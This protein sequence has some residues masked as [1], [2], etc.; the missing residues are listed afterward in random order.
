MRFTAESRA[1]AFPPGRGFVRVLSVTVAA[2]A[3]CGC[4]DDGDKASTGGTGGLLVTGTG[5]NDGGL[6]GGKPGATG[7]GG[8]SGGT[9]STGGR[10]SV[11]GTTSSG[12]T[13]SSGGAASSGGTRPSG[14]GGSAAT[15]QPIGAICVNDSNCSQ[16]QGMATC[17]AIPTCTGPCECRLAADCPKTGLFLECKGAADCGA[18]GGGKVCCQIASGSQTMQYCTKPSGCSGK[19]LP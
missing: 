15:G 18:F 2:L 4:S 1:G 16:S 14:G 12:G 19:V 7:G 8:A 11:S 9:T 17:C 13:A 5:A 3:V 10:S 6:A